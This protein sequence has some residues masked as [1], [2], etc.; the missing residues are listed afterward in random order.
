MQG[1]IKEDYTTMRLKRNAKNTAHCRPFECVI[2]GDTIIHFF[3]HQ[4]IGIF[5]FIYIEAVDKHALLISG[6]DV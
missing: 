3:L 1:V 6:K 5:V 2:A 4:C